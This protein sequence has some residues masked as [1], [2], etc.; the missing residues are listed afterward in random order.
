MR[1]QVIWI[2][3]NQFFVRHQYLR[4]DALKYTLH[5]AGSDLFAVVAGG[6]ADQLPSFRF[7]CA[8]YVRNLQGCRTKQELCA[9][10]KTNKL[11]QR[12]GFGGELRASML[13]RKNDQPTVESERIRLLL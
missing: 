6:K 1:R 5:V 11:H 4:K 13:R 12:N 9:H 10:H 3:T 2:G 7:K 8:L